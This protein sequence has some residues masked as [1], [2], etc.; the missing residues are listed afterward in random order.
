MSL[1]TLTKEEVCGA[2]HV[3]KWLHFARVRTAREELADQVWW[4]SRTWGALVVIHA[5]II[6]PD[7]A[8]RDVEGDS[9]VF[10]PLH[11]SYMFPSIACLSCW[12]ARLSQ[13][14]LDTE[15]TR[16]IHNTLC[17]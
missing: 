13:H 15:L 4:E 7:A 3:D 5:L 6:Y 14:T 9:G 11:V 1:S 12:V 2:L 16:M 17:C 8:S 10:S